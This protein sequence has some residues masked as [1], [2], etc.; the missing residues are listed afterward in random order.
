MA[1]E[2]MHNQTQWKIK[3]RGEL[4]CLYLLLFKIERFVI[5]PCWLSNDET[6]PLNT[7]ERTERKS[8]VNATRLSHENTLFYNTNYLVYNSLCSN[9][10]ITDFRSTRRI[11]SWLNGDICK[12]K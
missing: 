1:E 9:I 12:Q 3:F 6:G 8:S 10:K 5:L 11:V 4:F 7:L 2:K